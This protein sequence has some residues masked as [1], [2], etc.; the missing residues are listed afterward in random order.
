MLARQSARIVNAS[1]GI[2]LGNVLQMILLQLGHGCLNLRQTALLSHRLGGKVGV[3]PR[4]IPVTG[5]DLRVK[6]DANVKVLCNAVQQE[7]GHPHVITNGDTLA[8]S[9]LARKID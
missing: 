9:H 5:N 3:C 7:T 1:I 8:G 6:G 4:P 2:I